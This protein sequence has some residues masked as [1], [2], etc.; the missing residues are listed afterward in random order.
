MAGKI[1]FPFP[2]ET[3]RPPDDPFPADLTQDLPDFFLE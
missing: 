3:G 1:L 2:T